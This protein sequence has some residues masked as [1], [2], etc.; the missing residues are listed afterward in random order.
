[1]ADNTASNSGFFGKG[2]P[3]RDLS[4][5]K[6]PQRPVS[7]PA[8][9]EAAPAKDTSVLDAIQAAHD[10]HHA[11]ATF[12]DAPAP[13][14][15]V[16]V[17][18]QN[19]DAVPAAPAAPA[20][21]VP[22]SFAA[23]ESAA[24]EPASFFQAPEPAPAAPAAPVAAPASEGPRSFSEMFGNRAAA[25]APVALPPVAEVEQVLASNPA[26]AFADVPQVQEGPS[27]TPPSIAEVPSFA[28][29]DFDT[30][31][32][33][34]THAAPAEP[35]SF[36]PA[37]FAPAAEPAAAAPSVAEIAVP[38]AKAEA[39]AAAVFNALPEETKQHF[40]GSQF[41]QISPEKQGEFGNYLLKARNEGVPGAES[42][43]AAHQ[44][45]LQARADAIGNTL[46]ALNE[47]KSQDGVSGS[48][49]VEAAAL[50]VILEHSSAENPE[51]NA[52]LQVGGFDLLRK[53]ADTLPES[54]TKAK[55]VDGAEKLL[56]SGLVSPLSS[57]AQNAINGHFEAAAAE[58]S[59]SAQ[60]TRAE[61]KVAEAGIQQQQT[62]A[63]QARAEDTRS[64]AANIDADRA[65][66]KNPAGMGQYL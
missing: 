19:F 16:A 13:Q 39:S 52:A 61:L 4:G 37:S 15:P 38:E 22:P 43:L 42:E 35:I 34:E 44:Q 9:V 1:M 25:A 30:A 36:A 12:M 31:P 14:G 60:E 45:T 62:Q 49:R 50:R 24:V 41:D 64:W 20:E 57:T 17:T 47:L 5:Y 23:P 58:R 33:A 59:A 56:E 46:S 6:A 51:H 18:T 8:P 26:P 66:G 63:H 7:A 21:F 3:L 2:Q 27:F 11:P 28:A 55:I 48:D 32:A 10:A 65:A 53:L 29:P 40:G 54:E